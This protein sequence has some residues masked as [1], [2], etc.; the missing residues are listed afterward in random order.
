MRDEHHAMPCH[1][2]PFLANFPSIAGSCLVSM[3]SPLHVPV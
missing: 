1:A 2:M 3:A